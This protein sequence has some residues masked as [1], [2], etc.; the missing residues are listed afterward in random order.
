MVFRALVS[1]F[2]A[3]TNRPTFSSHASHFLCTV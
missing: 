3:K 2:F 1:Y